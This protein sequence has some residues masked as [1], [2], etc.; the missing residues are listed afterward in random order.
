VRL[1]IEAGIEY[2]GG[3]TTR[4]LNNHK[5][6]N[7]TA[8]RRSPEANYLVPLVYSGNNELAQLGSIH[9]RV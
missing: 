9:K 5:V 3:V 8:V 6:R 1:A 2:D 4:A 7:R